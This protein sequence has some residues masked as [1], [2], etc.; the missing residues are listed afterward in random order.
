MKPTF[1]TFEGIEGVGK[2]TLIQGLVKHLVEKKY[3]Y[4]LTREPGGTPL[5]EHL[6]ACLLEVRD[7]KVSPMTELLLM[8]ASRAQHLAN[9]IEPALAEGKIVLCD[10][11][12]DA[13]FAYQGGGR[14]VPY[15]DIVQLAKMVHG[16][17]NPNLTFLLDLDV[18]AAL[19]RARQ[20]AELDRFE[21]EE[22]AFFERARQAYL[23]RAKTEPQRFYVLDASKTPQELID[24]AWKV[25]KKKFL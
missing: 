23:Q 6:R 7:E 24:E 11:F 20:R 10:R 25:I 4:C 18:N 21:S 22:I 5:A 15:E 17:C 19:H 9:V 13:S 3:A 2:S 8:F 1:I 12:T 16:H 14:G